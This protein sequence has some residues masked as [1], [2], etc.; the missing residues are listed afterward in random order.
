MQRIGWR[1]M[2]YSKVVAVMIVDLH[3]AGPGRFEFDPAEGVCFGWRNA[4]V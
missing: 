1:E 3:P 4:S 2:F